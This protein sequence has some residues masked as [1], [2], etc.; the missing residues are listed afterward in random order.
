V[1]PVTERPTSV[2]T[3]AERIL[4]E[5]RGEDLLE[6]EERYGSQ[7]AALDARPDLAEVARALQH[8]RAQAAAT[9]LGLRL[10]R[11][12]HPLPERL[13]AGIE[14]TFARIVAQDDRE[15]LG[16]VT[17]SSRLARLLDDDG[18]DQRSQ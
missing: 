1:R 11:D 15:A 17:A 9:A 8:A 4:L 14:R 16:D 13:L 2:L 6:L 18:L 3:S 10:R 5:E 12:A 7:Q